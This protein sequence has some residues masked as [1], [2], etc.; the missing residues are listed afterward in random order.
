MNLIFLYIL[1]YFYHFQ[2]FLYYKNLVR[3]NLGIRIKKSQCGWD[4]HL[5][6]NFVDSV[7][8]CNNKLILLLQQLQIISKYSGPKLYKNVRNV[9]VKIWYQTDYIQKRRGEPGLFSFEYN[10][11][12]KLISNC[13]A[14]HEPGIRLPGARCWKHVLDIRYQ[15]KVLCRGKSHIAIGMTLNDTLCQNPYIFAD[16]HVWQDVKKKRKEKSKACSVL[17][18]YA[19]HGIN[20]STK[21]IVSYTF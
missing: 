11:L 13:Y 20:Y 6:D 3:I 12:P 17:C 14:L 1:N 4:K 18:F 5:I 19:E 10:L 2:P 16:Y 7:C 9:V 21:V 8:I 15:N